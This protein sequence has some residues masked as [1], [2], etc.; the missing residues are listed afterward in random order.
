M[1][2]L[3]LYGFMLVSSLVFCSEVFSTDSFPISEEAAAYQWVPRYL[4]CVDENTASDE[5]VDFLFGVREI[6][7]SQGFSVPLLSEI[8]S[9]VL[10]KIR[11]QSEIQLDEKFI[12]CLYEEVLS[13]ENGSF[14]LISFG[15]QKNTEKD[16]MFLMEKKG[17]KSK[18]KISNGFAKGFCKTLGGALLAIIPHPVTW[19]VG[20]SLFASGIADMVNHADDFDGI[21]MEELN[22]QLRERQRIGAENM[23]F[24]P[25]TRSFRNTEYPI[26][27]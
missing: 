25:R 26:S 23:S 4:D 14:D 16:K 12:E 8:F 17:K 24:S 21:T 20:G 22:R 10:E 2:I 3:R 7:I 15:S 9:T 13:I 19:G 5:V 18:M 6:M 11:V 27:A 1:K